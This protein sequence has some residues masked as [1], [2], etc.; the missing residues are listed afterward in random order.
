MNHAVYLLY[1]PYLNVSYLLCQET[2][3]R[4]FED[5]LVSLSMNES[6]NCSLLHGKVKKNAREE[7]A[8]LACL[9]LWCFMKSIIKDLKK[10]ING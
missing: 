4:T 10:E 6:C 9:F 1:L 7:K 3:R 8:I 2:S 5:L